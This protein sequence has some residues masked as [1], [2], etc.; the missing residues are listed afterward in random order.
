MRI[1]KFLCSIALCVCWCSGSC[2]KYLSRFETNSQWRSRKKR[3]RLACLIYENMQSKFQ[4]ERRNLNAVRE[5]LRAV[6]EIDL[7]RLMSDACALMED[8]ALQLLASKLS[9]KGLFRSLGCNSTR[10][11][12]Y[13]A[14]CEWDLF[15]FKF[16]I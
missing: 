11:Q 10:P 16:Y 15:A 1:F 14:Y 7:A 4:E 5:R 6:N 12:Q 9:F 2:R 13:S 3:E 8:E